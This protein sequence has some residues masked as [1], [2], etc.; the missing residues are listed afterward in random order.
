MTPTTGSP[1]VN[2]YNLGSLGVNR[3]LSPVHKTDGEFTQAQNVETGKH[4]QGRDAIKK[5]RGMLLYNALGF[6]TTVIAIHNLPY[7]G[8]AD[9]TGSTGSTGSTTSWS[10]WVEPFATWQRNGPGYWDGTPYTW[11]VQGTWIE[12]PW[13][14]HG[15]SSA[16]PNANMA[17]TGL[18]HSAVYGDYD[19]SL[20]Q[21]DIVEYDVMTPA[22]AYKS[23]PPAAPGANPD[24]GNGWR[25]C[26]QDGDSDF[27]TITFLD[28][29][30][31]T[32]Y[33]QW[34]YTY[35]VSANAWTQVG[36]MAQYGT[37]STYPVMTGPQDA[38]VVFNGRIYILRAQKKQLSAIQ[39]YIYTIES[40]S[41]T[42]TGS[43]TVE[44]TWDGDTTYQ[45]T[46]ALHTDGLALFVFGRLGGS[47]G[48]GAP[49]TY[50]NK[51]SYDGSTW[52]D[53]PSSPNA[54]YASVIN[55]DK[56]RTTG[57]AIFAYGD[58][59]NPGGGTVY[60]LMV[61]VDQSSSWTTVS[62]TDAGWPT[63]LASAAYS[64]WRA[65]DQYFMYCKPDGVNNV[66]VKSSASTAPAFN[67]STVS[68]LGEAIAFGAASGQIMSLTARTRF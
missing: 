61:S 68:D 47:A 55:I 63:G 19:L 15:Y 2:L 34:M 40:A 27:V 6:G 67:W 64:I 60:P 48:G 13:N 38:S 12:P 59:F 5:R 17:T 23:S 20:T 46:L 16:F 7:G 30:L 52:T 66:V 53:S 31:A 56:E 8:F 51:R 57:G 9:S 1:K 28:Y 36:D 35:Q 42:S 11:S 21:G 43:W 10:G 49:Y 45:S 29:A 33:R 32:G 14:S 24:S 41:A 4:A 58:A 37:G 44:Y 50:V 65:G 62:Q 39:K 54:I 18:Y 22:Y 3:V 25:V 26:T